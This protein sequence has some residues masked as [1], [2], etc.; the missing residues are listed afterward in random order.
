[1]QE[2]QTLGIDFA[3]LPVLSLIENHAEAFHLLVE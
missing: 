3:L 2:L 1:M